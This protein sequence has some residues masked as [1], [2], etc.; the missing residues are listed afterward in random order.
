MTEEITV[1]VDLSEI[2]DEIVETMVE[3]YGIK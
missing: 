1:G 2:S 3:M